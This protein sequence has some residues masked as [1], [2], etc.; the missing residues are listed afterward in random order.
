MTN[1]VRWNLSCVSQC[2]GEVELIR[3]CSLHRTAFLRGALDAQSDPTTDART[4][5]ARRGH[6]GRTQG[7][8]TGGGGARGHHSAAQRMAPSQHETHK[9]MI[10]RHK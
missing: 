10:M 8:N 3:G 9:T 5:R 2:V 6:W 1:A 4:M 7:G